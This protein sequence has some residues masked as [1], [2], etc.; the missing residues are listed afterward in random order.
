MSAFE[1]F[2]QAIRQT[3]IMQ[4]FLADLEKEPVTILL[5]ICREYELRNEAVADHRFHVSGYVGELAL[6]ALLSGGLV[7]RLP[8]GRL[9]VYSYKPTQTGMEFYRRL[10]SEGWGASNER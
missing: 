3:E 7:E 10:K 8:G 6:Q 2:T 4:Q 1:D 5:A 9:S